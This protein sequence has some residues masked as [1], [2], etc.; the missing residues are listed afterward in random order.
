MNFREWLLQ[1]D[2]KAVIA[3]LKEDG[4]DPNDFNIDFLIEQGILQRGR[5]WF[6]QKVAAPA[7]LAATMA[8]SPFL[9]GMSQARGA[10]PKPA[11]TQASNPAL[12]NLLATLI[13]DVP[14]DISQQDIEKHVVDE[15]KKKYGLDLK[16]NQLQWAKPSEYISKFYGKDWEKAYQKAKAYSTSQQPPEDDPFGAPAH[17]GAYTDWERFDDEVLVID[18]PP[19]RDPGDRA[20]SG[21]CRTTMIGGNRVPFCFV[22]KDVRTPDDPLKDVEAHELQHASQED[23]LAGPARGHEYLM[24]LLAAKDSEKKQVMYKYL[25]KTTEMAAWIGQIK[26]WYHKKTG[27]I[28][29]E[30][31]AKEVMAEIERTLQPYFGGKTLD[32][33]EGDKKLAAEFAKKVSDNN[34]DPIIIF[35]YLHNI[36][37]KNNKGPSFLEMMN[38]YLGGVV[39]TLHPGKTQLAYGSPKEKAQRFGQKHTIG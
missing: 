27:K 34:L 6:R 4:H 19:P 13:G 37:Q 16:P 1:E 18:A 28:A 14:K 2:R 7:T 17:L 23:V 12:D 24:N 8:A 10:E 15:M 22:P 39:K 21:N 31:S 35:Y 3:F 9:G 11:Q 38:R 36:A 33:I 29:D 25:S 32:E 30:T 20:A 26:R 5:D